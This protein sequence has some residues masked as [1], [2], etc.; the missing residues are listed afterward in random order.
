MSA[1]NTLSLTFDFREIIY[2]KS[3]LY[4]KDTTSEKA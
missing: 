2:V 1:L 3:R 4:E